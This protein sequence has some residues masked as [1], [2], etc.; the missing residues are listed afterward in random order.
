MSFISWQYPFL[1]VSV[2]LL[3]W[4][5]PL[6]GRLGLVLGASYI[7]YGAWD[8]RFLGLI[9]FSTVVDFFG[10]LA[11]TGYFWARTKVLLFSCLPFLWLSIYQFIVPTTLH[12]VPK[13]GLIAAALFIPFYNF[14]YE[15]LSRLKDEMRP[16]AFLILSIGTNLVVLGFFK[17]ANFFSDTAQRGL[18]ALGL[19][20]H[21]PVL[22]VLLPIGISFYTFQSI[23]Y[24]TDVY[25]RQAEPCDDPLTFFTFIAFFPQLVAGPI[26][27]ARQ[28]LPQI[29]SPRA[30]EW[31][32]I[33]AGTRLILVGLFL[34]VYVADNCALLANY[35]FNPNVKINA[36]WALLGV[37]AF[38]FQIYGD[39]AGYTQIA[40]GSARLL[41]IELVRNFKFP[42]F[43]RGP[44]DFWQR[45]HISLSEWFR[46]YVYIPLGGNRGTKIFVLRNL[47]VTMLV[48]GLW[49][50]ASWMF[51]LWGGYYGLLLVIYRV[52]PFLRKWEMEGK[53]WGAPCFMFVLTLLGWVLFRSSS[54][55]MVAHWYHSLTNWTISG[56]TAWRKPL[57]WLI[58][59]VTPLLMLQFLMRKEVD[60]AELVKLNIPLRVFIYIFMIMAIVSAGSN[61]QEFIYFQ[62]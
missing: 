12:S 10:G 54:M 9:L 45:W 51:V 39:F 47:A 28:L 13:L 23:A 35:A 41:G 1:L 15:I 20:P 36:P 44:S 11:I 29:M 25:R 21:W 56:Y 53:D 50:G 2:V 49:H 4:R 16:K 30:F 62:F 34:K 52:F 57:Y 60:E 27:R 6:R 55:G 61:D 38:A 33:Y 58:L 59:H 14:T 42:Y 37:L 18:M 43:S 40:R 48:A 32:H 5:L 17:Y 3:Y 8:A 19:H 46:D 24:V 26:E 22:H 31:E 7:F